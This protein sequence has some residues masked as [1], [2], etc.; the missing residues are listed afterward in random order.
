M[1][2][3]L[4]ISLIPAEIGRFKSWNM[5]R[6]KGLFWGVLACVVLTLLFGCKTVSYVPVT[7]QLH[8]SVYVDRF[9]RDSVYL[10]DSVFVNRYSKGDTV[11]VDKVVTKYAYKDKWRYDTVAIVRADSVRVPYPVEK[12]LTKWEEFKHGFRWV[13]IGVV[14]AAVSWVVVWLMKKQKNK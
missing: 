10:H 1:G 14:M 6:V 12:Q 2:L 3:P 8:D 5:D 9:H 4:F 7:Q 11:Y 13:F